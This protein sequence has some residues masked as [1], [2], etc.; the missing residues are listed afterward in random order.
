[1]TLYWINVTLHVLAAF[2]WL[3]GT[4]FLGLVGAPV[5]RRVEPPELR[6][7]L[8]RQLGERFRAIGWIA[9]LV[10]LVTGVLNLR[11]R[12][13]LSAEKLGDPAFWGTRYGRTLGWKLGA[14]AAI[15]VVSAVHDL[16]VGPRAS[17][18]PPGS[19]E[20]LRARRVTAWLG[21][22]AAV[23]GAAIVILAVRLARGG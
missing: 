8:F 5:L 17:R 20:A 4:F 6:A 10:L 16:V 21:R 19:P 12:G 22:I 2:V 3:G 11:F 9:V 15:V 23:L 14:V 1:M 7:R 13:L 18:S